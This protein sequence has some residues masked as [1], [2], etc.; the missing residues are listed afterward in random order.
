[1]AYS[2]NEKFYTNNHQCLCTENFD[3][4]TSIYENPNCVKS[5]CGI[6]VSSEMINKIRIGCVPVFLQTALCPEKYKCRKF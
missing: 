6:A 5:G 3:N 4:T 2:L 1:M